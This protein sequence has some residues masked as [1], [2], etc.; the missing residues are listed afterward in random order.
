MHVG[1]SQSLVRYEPRESESAVTLEE[2]RQEFAAAQGFGQSALW[3]KLAV[4]TKSGAALGIEVEID[5]VSIFQT[6]R[7]DHVRCWL[8]GDGSS[9]PLD[10]KPEALEVL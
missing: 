1:A 7:A 2:L 9:Y 6:R 4:T 10:V 3:V 8:Q 5:D